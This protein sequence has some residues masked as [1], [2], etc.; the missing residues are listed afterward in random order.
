MHSLQ[1]ALSLPRSA[2][3][4]GPDSLAAPSVCAQQPCRA[5]LAA[6]RTVWLRGLF[7]SLL[8][9]VSVSEDTLGVSPSRQ[10]CWGSFHCHGWHLTLVSL[11]VLTLQ[12][13][14]GNSQFYSTESLEYS[15]T[16]LCIALSVEVS[17]AFV[18]F[19]P[20]SLCFGCY[21]EP[22]RFALHVRVSVAGVWKHSLFSCHWFFY[23]LALLDSY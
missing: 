21:W 14:L 7:S 2:A 16:N 17:R 4:S 9:S 1:A 23:P 5:P 6:L 18:G 15:L 19:T 20:G 12:K 8:F 10:H 22:S 11:A 13:N 3:G